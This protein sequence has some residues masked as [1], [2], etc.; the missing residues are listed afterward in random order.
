METQN[1]TF[2][3][4]LVSPE[5][6][7]MSGPV[8]FVS[9]PGEEGDFGVLA[10]HSALVATIRPGVLEIVEFGASEPKRIFISGGFADVSPAGCTVLAE[11]AIAVADLKAE[12]LEL[13]LRNLNEDLTLARDDLERARIQRKI[14]LTRAKLLGVQGR[15]A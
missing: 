13:S 11:E 2:T 6:K 4:E 7:L 8:T 10:G 14:T 9:I 5:R 1:N 12:D 15:A 3:F